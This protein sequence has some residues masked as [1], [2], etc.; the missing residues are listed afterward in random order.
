[1]NITANSVNE[2]TRSV[3]YPSARPAARYLAERPTAA[4]LFV[5][6]RR[7]DCR[8]CQSARRV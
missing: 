2:W 4:M 1:M 8:R 5:R 3:I 7:R 6:Y